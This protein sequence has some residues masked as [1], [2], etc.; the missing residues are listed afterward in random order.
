M[1]LRLY[2]DED[3]MSQSLAMA[4]RSRGIDVL[5]AHEAGTLEASDE[6]QLRFATSEGR[7]VY[8]FNVR[9]FY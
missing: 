2:F 8:S 6:E 5:T 4:L 1:I 7:A 3:S 9:D